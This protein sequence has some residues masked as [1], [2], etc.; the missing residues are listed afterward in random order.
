[1]EYLLNIIDSL[2]DKMIALDIAAI[3]SSER[4][5]RVYIYLNELNETNI[6]KIKEYVDSPAVEFRQQEVVLT[7][8]SSE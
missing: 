8:T 6:N 3:A 7:F 2:N 4:N 1:M 5:N